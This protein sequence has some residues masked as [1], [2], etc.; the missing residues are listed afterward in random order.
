MPSLIDMR[1]RIRAVK[2]TQQ[3]TKAMKM[4]AASKLR[5]AQE[6]VLATRPF[7]REARRVLESIAARVDQTA[8]PLLVQRPGVTSGSTLLIV[9]TADRGLCGSF[10]SNIIKA[11]AGFLRQHPGRAVSLGL[12]G[13]KGRDVLGRRGLSVR[14]DY[15]N[16]PKV[17]RFAE[18]E[19]V[20]EP[21]LQ[22][23]VAAT[24]DSVHLVYN[25]FKSVIAQKVV[26][27]QLL[28][29]GRIA[30]DESPAGLEAGEYLYEPSAQRIFDQLL[31]RLVQAQILRALLESAAAE[32]AARMT[33]MDAA[34]RNSA[35]MIEDL[36]LSMNK[37][38]QAAI[39]REIIEVVSGAQS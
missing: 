33:A 6:R 2:N 12:V 39:T 38:R 22:D 11:V 9:M 15:V 3:I 29:L 17:I 37:I 34:T 31:G 19:A 4:V 20:A 25:E 18:A 10:N 27:E 16:L 36:T 14:F 26:V 1:R 32:Q 24:V 28:P 23:F 30:A 7:A 8:H 5:R 13:R 21:A 35:D